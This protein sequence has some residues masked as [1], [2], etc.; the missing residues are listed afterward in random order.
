[1]GF[2]NNVRHISAMWLAGILMGLERLKWSSSIKHKLL[3][4]KKI[5]QLFRSSLIYHIPTYF[6]A[7]LIRCIILLQI[8][9]NKHFVIVLLFF[10]FYVTSISEVYFSV[11]LLLFVFCCCCCFYVNCFYFPFE[12]KLNLTGQE[13]LMW[14]KTSDRPATG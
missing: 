5:N 9:N 4:E 14:Q 3:L 2:R 13:N 11:L 12:E 7:L 10:F 1:M 8:N 6:L